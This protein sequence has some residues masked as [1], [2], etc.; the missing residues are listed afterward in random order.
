MPTDTVTDNGG[1]AFVVPET[2]YW[3]LAGTVLPKHRHPARS[4][5]PRGLTDISVGNWGVCVLISICLICHPPQKS[6]QIISGLRH[7]SEASFL[8]RGI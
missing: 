2:A 1:E 5:M 7:G 4:A 6:P 8:E 3:N